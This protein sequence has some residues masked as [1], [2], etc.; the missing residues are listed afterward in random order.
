MKFGILLQPFFA[1]FHCSDFTPHI[2]DIQN[3]LFSCYVFTIINI[4][5]A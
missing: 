5:Y 4:C 3:F 1:F 2:R